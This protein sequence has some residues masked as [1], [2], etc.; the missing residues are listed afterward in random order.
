MGFSSNY[1]SPK[2]G[3]PSSSTLT[4]RKDVK[5][6]DRAIPNN[7]QIET[8]TVVACFDAEYTARNETDKG[9]QEMIQCALIVYQI[10]E[11]G[12]WHR[13]DEYV[14]FV[15]P[16]Y[17]PKLSEFIIQFTNI[18]Q[19]DVDKAPLFTVVAEEIY[20]LIKKHNIDTIYVWGPDKPVLKYNM[21]LTSYPIRKSRQILNKMRDVSLMVSSGL[22]VDYIMSQTHACEELDIKPKGTQ[23]NAYDDAHNLQQVMQKYIELKKQ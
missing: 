3:T 18:H 6:G 17:V 4:K 2:I 7:M 19:E 21:E 10:D 15:R 22:G 20:Q 12:K 8:N 14:K 11:N 9:I 5:E 16:I 23:H 1:E 13:I